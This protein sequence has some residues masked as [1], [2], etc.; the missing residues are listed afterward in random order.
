M[1][2]TATT[3]FG[4]PRWS[5]GTDPLTRAQI[6]GAMAAIEAEAASYGQGTIAARP[7]AS[8]ANQGLFYTV[9]D[10]TGGGTLGAVYYCDG[11]TWLGPLGGSGSSS[12]GF[13]ELFLHGGR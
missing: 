7:A 6:D 2:V 1:S 10:A 4:L 13:A 5:A 9:N 3:R 8:A 12:V 11:A